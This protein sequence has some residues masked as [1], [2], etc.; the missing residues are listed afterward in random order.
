MF[1]L[2]ITDGEQTFVFS[3]QDEQEFINQVLQ[4]K[5]VLFW[6]EN[7]DP[8][9]VEDG[10]SLDCWTWFSADDLVFDISDWACG[11]ATIIYNGKEV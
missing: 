8:D 5:L 11:E 9:C 6:L 1:D 4:N 2:T 10:C 7:A 3:S